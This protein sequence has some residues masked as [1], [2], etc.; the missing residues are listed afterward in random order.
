MANRIQIRRGSGTPTS[1]NLLQ[2]ELGW[3]T[4]N[5]KL[6]IKSGSGTASSDYTQ[7]SPNGLY[8]P[9]S[10][11]GTVN[12]TVSFTN[13]ITGNISGYASYATNVRITNTTPTSGTSYY[14][15]FTAGTAANTNYALRGNAL[16]RIWIAA[17]GASSYLSLGNS[18]HAGGITLYSSSGKYL[19][20]VT[21]A[22]ADSNKT[23]TFPNA[24]GTVALTSDLSSYV[25]K[26]GDTMTNNLTISK[27][28]SPTLNLKNTTMDTKA[29]S[30]STEQY[31]CLY[32]KDKNDYINAFVQG[33]QY[34]NGDTVVVLATRRR[35]T[36]NNNNVQSSL[37]LRIAA[38]G[39][40]TVTVSS[41]AAWRSAIAAVDKAGD[42]MTG[43]LRLHDASGVYSEGS[44]IFY[45]LSGSTSSY[46]KQGAIF[47]NASTVNSKK[48][49]ERLYFREYSYNS[50]TG[51]AIEQWDQYRL[52]VVAADKTRADTYE[53]LTSKSAVT[54]AQGG[55]GATTAANAIKA[56][57]NGVAT[58][59][60]AVVTNDTYFIRQ[61]DSNYSY[62][63]AQDIATYM[64]NQVNIQNNV[65][66]KTANYTLTAA[67]SGKFI[68]VNSS[69]DLTITIP[70]NASSSIP[71]GAEYTIMRQGSGKVTINSSS[72]TAVCSTTSRNLGTKRTTL[73]KKIAT[74]TWY[75]DG[76]HLSS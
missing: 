59:V 49:C 4:T 39:T 34:T 20:L 72:I 73:L 62:V 57:L 28:G 54:I 32:F 52:P 47:T 25:L 43:V 60:G 24:T 64:I 18:S 2:Y 26:A 67:D 19:D 13:T 65:L 11:G 66:N 58:S 1:N 16:V 21:S 61:K 75:I 56:L 15:T 27:T 55:T 46:Q 30:I 50:S 23:I 3:D 14:L 71:I 7:I 12:G 51:A 40:E 48:V 53:I 6:Y 35:N 22:M 76:D 33:S 69:S 68:V 17:D 70:T 36:A 8:L 44:P 38:S 74:D 45:W 63:S 10:G 42:T 31:N 37:T 9:L 5:K 29:A 41:P